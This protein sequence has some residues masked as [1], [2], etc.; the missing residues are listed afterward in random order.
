MIRIRS[1]RRSEAQLLSGLDDLLRPGPPIRVFGAAWRWR[2]ELALVTGV[3]VMLATF[4]SVLGTEWTVIAVSALAGALAPPWPRPMI[5]AAWRVITPHRLRS[6]CAQARIQSTRG[7]L[8]LV[9][10]TTSES[11]GEQV[12]LWCPAG[13][14]AEDLRSARAILRAACWAADVRITQ[15]ERHT[16]I[17][18]VDVIRRGPTASSHTGPGHAAHGPT[19]PAPTPYDPVGPLIPVRGTGAAGPGVRRTPAPGP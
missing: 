3:G 6:G 1:R 8:P 7:R 18:T 4:L 14:S 16:H 10:R 12:R 17:V 5:A 11:F 15:D 13:T 19:A 9:M 2:Y